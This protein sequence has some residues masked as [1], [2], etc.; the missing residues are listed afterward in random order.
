[1]LRRL[2]LAAATAAA[3][4]TP[5]TL[6]PAASAAIDC[7]VTGKIPEIT[8]QGFLAAHYSVN[9][10]NGQSWT[11]YATVQADISGTWQRALNT[12]EVTFNGSGDETVVDPVESGAWAC[13]PGRLYRT[14]AV[15]G[16][17]NTDNSSA[18]TLC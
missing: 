9:C 11:V 4:A 14:H 2:L 10:T 12:N 15:L 6:A 3:V 16:N 7:T 5:L 1:M 18:I 17:G 13:T 8:Q